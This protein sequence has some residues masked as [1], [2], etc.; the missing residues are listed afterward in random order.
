MSSSID[1]FNYYD[2]LVKEGTY[3]MSEEWIS[4]LSSFVDTLVDYL[5]PFGISIPILTTEER[6]SIQSPVEGQMI[7]NTNS[8]VGPPRTAQLQVWQVKADVG[9]WRNITTV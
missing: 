8:T 7:Y 2:P 4:Q 1:Q 5:Q 6:D 3:K 9:A